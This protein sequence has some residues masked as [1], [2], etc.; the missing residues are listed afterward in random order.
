MLKV[1][2]QRNLSITSG[3]SLLKR[4]FLSKA[5]QCTEAWNARLTTSILEKV[6]LD[7][8]YYDLEQRFQQKHKVSA[9]DI[10]IYAN[11][12]VDDTHV[13]EI[14]D[15]LYKFR[16]TEEA[17]NTLDSTHHALVRNFLE[18]KCYDQL[19]DVLNNRIGYGVFLDDYS[20]N[21]VLDQLIKEKQFKYAARIATLLALQE[22]FAN[23][24]T[25]G[26]SL[27]S[28]YRYAKAPDSEH[29]DDLVPVAQETS[30]TEGPR[31]KKKEETK[32]RVKF[33]RNPFFDDHFDLKDSQLL[34][35][36]TFI[37]LGKSYGG[38]NT[39]I[40]A[41]CELLGMTMYRKYDQ[42]LSF[43]KEHAGKEVNAEVLQLVHNV[44]EKEQNG[45]DVSFA[46]FRDAV[47]KIEATMKIN[48]ENFEKL[49][50]A[51][52]EK[53]VA[54]SEKQQIEEQTKLYSEWCNQRQ[55]R[56]DDDLSRLQRAKRIK[57]M[58]QLTVEMEK[59]EQ[60]LWFFENEDKI[61]LQI[62][63]KRVFYPKR[64]FGKKKKPRTVDVDYV[65][66]EVRQRN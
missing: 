16:L 3:C 23:P 50:L 33:I 8:L 65:P 37:E 42:A 26:L 53:S 14:A 21:L 5:Y 6:N 13:D 54:D 36:K 18:H 58:E 17:S 38:S 34:L 27:Y 45:E 31:K 40:G 60:K 20:A 7:T 19:I 11:K 4:T 28:C 24:I 43:L 47:P 61:D 49:L 10:D 48:K 59:E 12:L 39:V 66:P 64:W 22:D 55:Q 44:L 15:L 32:V 63:S 41:S 51:L 57:E 52:V 1:F 35:G 29:F 46:A 25:R 2:V 30:E 62:D 9:L 56:L